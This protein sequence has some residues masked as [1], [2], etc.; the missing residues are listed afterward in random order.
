MTAENIDFILP[1]PFSVNVGK[2]L[3]SDTNK[4]IENPANAKRFGGDIFYVLESEA[5]IGEVNA[6][7]YEA[8]PLRVQ[9]IETLQGLLFIFFVSLIMRAILLR[10]ARDSELLDKKSIEEILLEL[11]K[12]RAVKVGGKW[13]LTAISKKQRTILEKMK[14]VI[15]RYLSAIGFHDVT[16]IDRGVQEPWRIFLWVSRSQVD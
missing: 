12:L 7:G 8:M 11:A 2:G 5:L 1:L 4:D 14:I 6:Y 15:A 16:D 10:K 3:I 9:K 13:R